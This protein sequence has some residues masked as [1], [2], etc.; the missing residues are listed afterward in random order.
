METTEL[1]PSLC[2]QPEKKKLVSSPD[3]GNALGSPLLQRVTSPSPVRNTTP[4]CSP[5]KV[6]IRFK[7]PHSDLDSRNPTGANNRIGGAPPDGASPPGTNSLI[8]GAP[9]DGAIGGAPPDG[10][11]GGAPPDGASP[12]GKNFPPKILEHNESGATMYEDSQGKRYEGQCPLC[13]RKA[14]L[15]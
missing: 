2:P 6:R 5:N 13:Q 9:P 4:D 15:L 10:T 3:R 11:I 8:G 12:P 1:I 14:S 7:R